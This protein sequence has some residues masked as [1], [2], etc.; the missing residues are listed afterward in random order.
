MFLIDTNVI[1][2]VRKG[3]RANPSVR[4]WFLHHAAEAH[5]LSV[6]T[7]GEIRRG[8]EKIRPKDAAQ[9]LVFE[10]SLAEIVAIFVGRILEVGLDEAEIWGRLCPH[11]RLPDV[12]ALLAATAIRHGL[13]VATRNTK[14]FV[15]SGVEVL[16]PWEFSGP[17]AAI[18]DSD[19][20]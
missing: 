9:A 4:A 5:Y 12:D 17:P 11:D 8:I 2:E 6:L 10:K 15:G 14:D 16:N 13:V 18:H 1:C 3:S 7:V 20:V 19:G